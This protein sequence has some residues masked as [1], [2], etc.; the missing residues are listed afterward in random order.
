MPVEGECLRRKG[1]IDL[2]V[3]KKSLC[4]PYHNKTVGIC[5]RDIFVCR[6]MCAQYFAVEGSR[7]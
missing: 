5:F 4:Y 3:E 1:G 7:C 6:H 2:P